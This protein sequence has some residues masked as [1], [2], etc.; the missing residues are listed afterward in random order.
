MVP[1]K[2][3]YILTILCA[4]RNTGIDGIGLTYAGKKLPPPVSSKL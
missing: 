1:K 3:R 2:A 4:M